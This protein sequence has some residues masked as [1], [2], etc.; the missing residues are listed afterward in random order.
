MAFLLLPLCNLHLFSMSTI[1]HKS[2]TLIYKSSKFNF[3]FI[4]SSIITLIHISRLFCCMA[5]SCPLL[6]R[7]WIQLFCSKFC[8]TGNTISHPGCSNSRSL[9]SQNDICLQR[10]G[11]KPNLSKTD[12]HHRRKHEW[13]VFGRIAQLQLNETSQ[14]QIIASKRPFRPRLSV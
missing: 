4:Y 5:S 2:F 9:R 6:Q 10:F 13:S 11:T 7:Y 14:K 1:V 12:E 8:S 3:V